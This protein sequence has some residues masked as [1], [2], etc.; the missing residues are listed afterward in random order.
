MAK[1]PKVQILETA[2]EVV[3]V[4]G[5]PKAVADELGLKANAVSNWIMRDEIAP[6]NYLLVTRALQSRKLYDG[7]KRIR[8]EVDPRVF[9]M[10][11]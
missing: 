7:R 2:R 5:G 10:L 1:K 3:Q 8:V 9:G 4:L 6:H 11:E